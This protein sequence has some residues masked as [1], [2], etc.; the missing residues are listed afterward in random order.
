MLAFTRAV[1]GGPATLERAEVTLDP[2]GPGE[3]QLRIEAVALNAS[4][5]ELLTGSPAY[6]RMYGLRTPAVPILGSDVAGTVLQVGSGVTAF[7]PGDAVYGDLFERWGGLAAR[8]NAPAAAL[9][10]KPPSLS[11]AEAA[12]IPQAGVVALQGLRDRGSI[13]PGQRVLINGAGGGSGTYAV[14]LAKLAGAHVTAVDRAEKFAVLR[15]LGADEVLD[16]RSVDFVTTGPYDRILDLV[17]RRSLWACRG[18]LAP[19]GVYVMAGGTTRC[20]LE[21]ALCG[22]LYSL[23]SRSLGILMHHQNPTDLAELTDLCVAGSVRP[24]IH[25]LY[26]FDDAPEAFAALIAGEAIGKVVV[27]GPEAT[28]SC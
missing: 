21:A 7:A 27:R 18:A 6:I 25:G 13:T 4:D 23:G 10:R 11:F 17:A 26:G 12:C 9:L 20:L 1:Y 24:V 16:H 3:V 19:T 28:G 15:S 14:Q 8:V 22:P 5:V 2:P